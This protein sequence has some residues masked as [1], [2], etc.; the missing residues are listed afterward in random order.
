MINWDKLN[1]EDVQT[2]AR[3][4]KRARNTLSIVDPMSLDM[5]ISAAHIA[6]PLDLDKLESFDDRNFAHD[7]YGIMRHIDRNTGKMNRCFL[8]RCSA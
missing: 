5:D 3:I 7:I 2:I 4:T 6:D 1:N 8:P